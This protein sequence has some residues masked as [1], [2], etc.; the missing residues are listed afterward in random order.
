MSVPTSSALP[1]GETE[2]PTL[3]W[4]EDWQ[5]RKGRRLRVLHIGNIANNAYLNA[6]FLRI[7]RSSKSAGRSSHLR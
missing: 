2:I 3:A 1:D 7:P 6:S 4:L 5:R